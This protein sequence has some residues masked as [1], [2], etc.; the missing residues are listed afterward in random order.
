MPSHAQ[1]IFEKLYADVDGYKLSHDARAKASFAYAGYVYGE[2]TYE[3]FSA[4]LE[5]AHPQPGEVFYDFGS[6]TGKAVILAALLYDFSKAVGIE[7]LGD[8]YEASQEVL[9]KF[10]PKTNQ[11]VEFIK[12]DYRDVDFS[13]ADIIFINATMMQYEFTDWFFDKLEKLKKETRIITS[14]LP[15]DLRAY[16]TDWLKEVPFTWGKET[17]YLHEKV[18]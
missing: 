9:G 16:D 7:I 3:G 5:K 1:Q 14:S 18:V 2:I 12:A 15:L 10:E 4:V 17:V 8:L 13:D 11:K 6:G